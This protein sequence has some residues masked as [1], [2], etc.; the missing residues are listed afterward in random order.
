MTEQQKLGD[1]I[2]REGTGED[3]GFLTKIELDCHPG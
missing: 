1:M 2:V 3:G